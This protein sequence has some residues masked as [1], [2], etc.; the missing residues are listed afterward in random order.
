MGRGCR[1]CNQAQ[2]FR[3][4][5]GEYSQCCRREGYSGGIRRKDLHPVMSAFEEWPF[6]KVEGLLIYEIFRPNYLLTNPLGLCIRCLEVIHARIAS[7][8]VVSNNISNVKPA[9]G[10]NFQKRG[11]EAGLLKRKKEIFYTLLGL[12]STRICG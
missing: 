8:F 10:D 11:K 6:S 3:V 5:K 4:F 9:N 7:K 2:N 1:A 12:A